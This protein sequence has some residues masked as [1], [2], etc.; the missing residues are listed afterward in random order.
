VAHIKHILVSE[1]KTQFFFLFLC[2]SV[3]H[4][5]LP[6]IGSY[7]CCSLQCYS[8]VSPIQLSSV[9]LL[10]LSVQAL[11]LKKIGCLSVSL[12]DY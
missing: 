5:K 10:G 9:S 4:I 6:I 12:V 11:V 3:A 7:D 2:A 1:D 8:E